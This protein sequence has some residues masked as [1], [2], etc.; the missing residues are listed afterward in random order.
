MSKKINIV[1][2]GLGYVGLANALLLAQTNDVVGL[3]LDQQKI[4]QLNEKIS[5]LDDLEIQEYLTHKQLHLK[6]DLFSDHYLEHADFVIVATPTNYDPD[7][8]YF[9]KYVL[10]GT[11]VTEWDQLCG[12]I[13][14]DFSE[15]EDTYTKFMQRIEYYKPAQ[16]VKEKLTYEVFSKKLKKSFDF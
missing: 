4:N 8:N 10:S 11:S 2:V 15:F 7:K 3:D 5:P 1:V 16:L 14:S 13:F 12:E 9:D 6:F